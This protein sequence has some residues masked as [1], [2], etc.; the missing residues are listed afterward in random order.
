MSE[1]LLVS[2]YCRT[3]NHRDYI[4]NALDGM[5][6]QD[7]DFLYKIVIYDDASTDGT[8]DIVKEYARKYPQMVQVVIMK[9]NTWRNQER[10]KIES[11]FMKKYLTG[12]YIAYCEGDDFWIDPHK[13]QIQVDYM[14]ANP[15]CSMYLH[16]ALWF[17]CM[18]NTMK[19]GNP[20][21]CKRAK[22]ISPEEIFMMYNGHPP[23]ASFLHKKEL[24]DMPKFFMES[25]VGDYTLLLYALFRG[26]VHYNN[27][28]MS[29]YRQLSIGSYSRTI[30]NDKILG[31]YYHFGLL[32]FCFKYNQYTNYKY[33]EW[34]DRKIQEYALKIIHKEKD[35]LI[36]DDY[37]KE[38]LAQRYIFSKDFYEYIKE[39]KRLQ[40]QIYDKFYISVSLRKFIEKYK[41]IIIMGVGNFAT[42]L[43]E[44]FANNHIEYNGFAVSKRREREDRYLEKTI[45]E[46]SELPYRRE[47]TGIIIGINPVDWSDIKNS[48]N[49]A[50]ILNYYCP[51]LYDIKNYID[52]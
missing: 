5:L 2:I 19:A 29:V 6:M 11:A 1:E 9:K 23:T 14:E 41:Y 17:N 32:Q 40:K 51:F 18:D 47:D 7:T 31:F 26:N 8:S 35:K 45:W 3:Y 15:K 48:L 46:L 4:H 30:Q 16:N 25:S 37:V 36:I 42:I 27:R 34:C 24:L 33:E 28:I 49:K 10:V 38:C 21:S 52:F 12:K 22:D 43:V 50:K 44:Q 20:Y 13:L 39:L